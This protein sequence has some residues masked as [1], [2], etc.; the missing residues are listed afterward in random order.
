VTWTEQVAGFGKRD[1][2]GT[3]P[4][5]LIHTGRLSPATSAGL[6][7]AGWKITPVPYPT[8]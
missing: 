3:A 4:K 7:A 6:T 2:L 1:D 8:R 5:V